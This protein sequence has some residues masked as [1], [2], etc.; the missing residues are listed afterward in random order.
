MSLF[1]ATQKPGGVLFTTILLLCANLVLIRVYYCRQFLTSLP[2]KIVLT[3][4]F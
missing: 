4:L 2:D 1:G 3:G